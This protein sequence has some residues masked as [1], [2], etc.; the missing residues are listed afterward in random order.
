LRMRLSCAT[1]GTVVA[2]A[3]AMLTLAASAAAEHSVIAHVSQGVT[4]GNGSFGSLFQGVSADGTTV[5]F[6]TAEQLTSADTDTAA[7][8]YMRRGGVTTLVSGGELQ[9]TGPPPEFAAISEDGSRIFFL[10]Q[11]T[12]T[13]DDPDGVGRDLFEYSDGTTKLISQGS[14]SDARFVR[15]E[16]ITPDGST[17]TTTRRPTAPRSPVMGRGSSSCRGSSWSRRTSTTTR[18][19]TSARPAH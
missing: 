19:S 2:S 3:V 6:S 1:L 12:L 16:A 15:F 5:V 17:S 14:M 9:R 8:L 11:D 7:D 4:G 10:T 18:T 13:T